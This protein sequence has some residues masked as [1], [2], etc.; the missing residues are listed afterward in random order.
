MFKMFSWL[1]LWFLCC[2][3]YPTPA[4]IP[5]FSLLSLIINSFI[6][7][8]PLLLKQFLY[9]LYTKKK[10]KQIHQF[11]Y[12]I[13]ILCYIDSFFIYP[14]LIPLLIF[15]ISFTDPFLFL[16]LVLFKSFFCP[17]SIPLLFLCVV[18]LHWFLF[19][20][21]VDSFA[22]LLFTS[23]TPLFWVLHHVFVCLVFGLHQ[24]LL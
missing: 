18:A 19:L 5:F 23:S 21:F 1:S 10:T 16:F 3:F 6:T 15:F 22:F 4:L 13:F 11:H 7:F 14:T 8:P 24:L 9:C 20:S 12:F 2:C 17:T